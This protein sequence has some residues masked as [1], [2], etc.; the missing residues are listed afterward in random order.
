[1]VRQASVTRA[2]VQPISTA[3]DL[4]CPRLKKR[5]R[6]DAKKPIHIPA[7]QIDIEAIF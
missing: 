6:D 3:R 2:P 4:S 5:R 1:M 7:P